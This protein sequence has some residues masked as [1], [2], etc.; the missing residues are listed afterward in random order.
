MWYVPS[1]IQSTVLAAQMVISSNPHP[2]LH[3][4]LWTQSK[5]VDRKGLASMP[6]SIQSA[7]VTPEV[8]L[9]IT[10]VRKHAK[11]DLPWLYNPGQM[12]QEAQNRGFTVAPQ[13]GLVPSYFFFKKRKEIYTASP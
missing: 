11:R 4:C 8:N 10:Q 7:S 3:Q 12:P 13:K 6:T 9:R 5:Y 2:N 1:G